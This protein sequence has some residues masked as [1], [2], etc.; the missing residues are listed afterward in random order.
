VQGAKWAT[1][2]FFH[3]GFEAKTIRPGDSSRRG[4]FKNRP[5]PA[6][7]YLQ[8]ADNEVPAGPGWVTARAGHRFWSPSHVLGRRT[9]PERVVG[10]LVLAA[11][12]VVA[13][14]GARPVAVSAN[15]RSRL[16]TV[17]CLV[18]HH[19]LAIDAA[20]LD[21][22][23]DK[24]RVRPGGPF[25]S[26]KPPTQALFLAGLYQL[27]WSLFDFHA[28][29]NIG[30]FVWLMALAGDGLPYAVAVWC[31][32]RLGRVLELPPGWA[33]GLAAS[34]GLATAAP[35]YTRHVNAHMPLLAA[36]AGVVL[37][38][39]VLARPGRRGG[40]AGRLLLAGTLAGLG[41][42]L[43]QPTGGLLLAAAAACVVWRLRRP[44]A[45]VWIAL[46]ALPWFV[47]HHAVV[48]SYAGTLTPVNSNAAFFAYPGSGFHAHNLTGFWN[49]AG[50]RAFAGYAL[51][52]LFGT[53]GFLLSNPTLLLGLLVAARLLYRSP[54]RGA[55]ALCRGGWAVAVWL[56]FAALSTNAG[57]CCW[58][59]RWLLP[60]LA[61]AYALLGWALRDLPRC[62]LDFLLLSGWGLV[63]TRYGWLCG[64][65]GDFDH[66][67]R[68]PGF[69]WSVQAAVLASWLGCRAVLAAPA[70]R[71]R[72]ADADGDEGYG[73]PEA[74]P[75]RMAG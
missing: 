32:Y 58:S 43:E 72:R 46:G 50:A 31:I 42:A 26:D 13:V 4:V 62:R 11:A 7:K 61:P 15:D 6:D 60:L 52:L 57:G 41:Y 66:D 16:A 39:A 33:A 70:W 63:L 14:L 71:Q 37:Q 1:L 28:A 18:E 36:A 49:H 68:F 54:G 40:A 17:E 20:R 59:V 44:A 74:S 47:L 24:I 55:E 64:T 3:P 35:V 73:A 65:F 45:G 67:A 53:R 9:F 69:F 34:F 75:T 56:T 10:S 27:L 29:D 22:C 25:Y 30:R 2:P 12:V 38:L 21:A 8:S 48:W 23:C 19:T 51:E 5:D